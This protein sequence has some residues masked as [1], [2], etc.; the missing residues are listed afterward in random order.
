MTVEAES[1]PSNNR[2]AVANHRPASAIEAMAARL[3]VDPRK[4]FDSLAATV[5]QGASNEEM[6]GLVV[7]AN[8]YRLNPFLKQIYAFP[9]KGGGIVPIVGVDGWSAIINNE[10][11]FDG[12][13]FLYD[14]DDG[15]PVSCTCVMHVKGRGHPIKVTEY[16]AE[17]KR[18]SDPWN[19]MPRR[20]LR[21]KA[22]MQCGRLAFGLGGIYDEDEGRDVAEGVVALTG[23]DQILTAAPPRP[24]TERLA[25]KLRDPGEVV[26]ATETTEV[27]NTDDELPPI[28]KET[29][30]A[31]RVMAPTWDELQQHG[32]TAAIED[33]GITV[34]DSANIPMNPEGKWDEKFSAY[35]VVGAGDDADL[36]A[37]QL[38]AAGIPTATPVKKPEPPKA[39]PPRSS[40]PGPTSPKN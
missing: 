23:G 18:S 10:P 30:K 6:L 14:D 11:S 22:F 36:K 37:R 9:K 1:V 17:C 35:T 26:P 7:V 16:F 13:E 28:G 32:I 33:S 39:P 3:K 25:D 20:M 31:Q 40:R 4:L 24:K 12:C 8:Q 38:A 2:L 5:F 21:H 27:H 29:T 19:T 15:E 34:F